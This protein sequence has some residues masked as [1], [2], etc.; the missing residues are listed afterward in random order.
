MR[1]DDPLVT[2]LDSGRGACARSARSEDLSGSTALLDAPVGATC[3]LCG[4]TTAGGAS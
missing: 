4:T 1:Y 3:E 2:S